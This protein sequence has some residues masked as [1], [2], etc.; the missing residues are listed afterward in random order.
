MAVSEKPGDAGGEGPEAPEGLPVLEVRTYAITPGNGGKFHELMTEGPVPM[1]RRWDVNVLFH[2]PASQDADRY[3]LMRRFE[4]ETERLATL[5]A[6]YGS[7]EWL[8]DW[9]DPV[10]AMI[11][12]YHVLSL[13]CDRTLADAFTVLAQ[14][15]RSPTGAG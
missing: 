1:L 9:D 13:P 14:T 8:R 11:G 6:F 5:G 2:G 3:I 12:N 10:M 7:E 4:S 15:T